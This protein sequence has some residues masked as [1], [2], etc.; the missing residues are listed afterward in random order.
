M[1]K[2]LTRM[3][4][5]LLILAMA[6]C[7]LGCGWLSAAAGPA[8][9]AALAPGKDLETELPGAWRATTDVGDLIIEGAEKEMGDMPSL[10]GYLEKAEIDIYFEFA[11]DSSYRCFADPL[12]L[13]EQLVD[14][15]V[16]YFM[17]ELP[18]AVGRELSQEEL[19]G[20][21]GMSLVEYCEANMGS[22]ADD[23]VGG[24]DFDGSYTVDGDEV[25]LDDGT[26]L[27]LEKGALV[28]DV[29]GFGTLSFV[30]ADLSSLGLDEDGLLCADPAL[31]GKSYEQLAK[32][33]DIRLGEI[34]DWE[35]FGEGLKQASANLGGVRAT[36]VFQDDKLILV[37][38]EGRPGTEE[39]PPAEEALYKTMQDENRKELEGELLREM[40]KVELDS[41]D[42]YFYR[43]LLSAPEQ[44]A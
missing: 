13:Q 7:M 24:F 38:Y 10:S 8:A 3:L 28:T 14:M 25:L 35:E 29:D 44:D 40:Q 36:F 31:F 1:M 23:F 32:D 39:E 22:I 21:L 19:E 18:K 17:V 12:D 4:A 5:S 16:S 42:G 33:S 34:S 9:L 2:T 15:M 20:L 6:L 43:Q 37:M 26:V 27:A 41:G 11:E 30:P